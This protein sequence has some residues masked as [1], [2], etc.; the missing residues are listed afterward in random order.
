M[1]LKNEKGFQIQ[2]QMQ[3]PSPIYLMKAIK[4]P[5][6]PFLIEQENGRVN[7]Y[8]SV[9]KHGPSKQGQYAVH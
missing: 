3:C 4:R 6:V 1:F 2:A 7:R 8:E 9:E 5:H